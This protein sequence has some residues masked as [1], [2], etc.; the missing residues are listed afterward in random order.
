[1]KTK[2]AK[3]V[4]VRAEEAEAEDAGVAAVGVVLRKS[5]LLHRGKRKQ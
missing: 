5:L 1:M 4:L 3:V 2:A